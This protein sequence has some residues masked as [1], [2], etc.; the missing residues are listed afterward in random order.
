MCKKCRIKINYIHNFQLSA[1]H[2][3]GII[4]IIHVRETSR[5]F[6]G[7]I[8]TE[9]AQEKI[10]VENNLWQIDLPGYQGRSR[11]Q[12]I[13]YWLCGCFV[14]V[15]ATSLYIYIYIRCNRLKLFWYYSMQASL[16][17][18]D[19]YFLFLSPPPYVFNDWCYNMELMQWL[20]AI[21]RVP[22]KIPSSNPSLASATE[23]WIT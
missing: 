20:H 16:F 23:L 10:S 17:G 12:L 18:F 14:M 5:L 15:D 11:I 9:R 7:N 8:L 4:S 22:S 13:V 6:G 3:A 19:F 21:H 2:V 1:N